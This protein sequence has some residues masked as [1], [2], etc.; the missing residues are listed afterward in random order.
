MNTW[1]PCALALIYIAAAGWV[2]Y[3]LGS[4]REQLRLLEILKPET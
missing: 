4:L 2:G 3:M 1:L